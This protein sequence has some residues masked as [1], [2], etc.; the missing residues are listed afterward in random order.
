MADVTG[1]QLQHLTQ[2]WRLTKLMQPS[3][4]LGNGSLHFLANSGDTP[5]FGDQPRQR[6]EPPAPSLPREPGERVLSDPAPPNCW[7][8]PAPAPQGLPCSP[9][10]A[11]PAQSQF[12]AGQPTKPPARAPPG[13]SPGTQQGGNCPWR[14]GGKAPPSSQVLPVHVELT[15][16]HPVLLFWRSVLQD[17]LLHFQSAYFRCGFGNSKWLR[18]LNPVMKND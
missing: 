18:S 8:S 13:S 9:S 14:R 2:F 16:F 3:A 1:Y 12:T 17:S 7:D 10:T 5:A 4:T 15:R 11:R 6:A